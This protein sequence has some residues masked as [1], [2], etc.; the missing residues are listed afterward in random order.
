MSTQPHVAR[1]LIPLSSFPEALRR[2]LS[3]EAPE[4]VAQM[5]ARGLVPMPP[6]L[7]VCALYQV[8]HLHPSLAQQAGEALLV[9]PDEALRAVLSSGLPPSLLEWVA[10]V[11][12]VSGS[13]DQLMWALNNPRLS[14]ESGARLIRDGSVAVCERIGNDQALLARAPRLLQALY[15]APQTPRVLKDK[16][17][18]WAHYMKLPLQRSVDPVPAPAR[19]HSTHA[20]TPVPEQ[21]SPPSDK[22]G[23]GAPPVE[24][25]E[26]GAPLIP[27]VERLP[28]QLTGFS[29]AVARFLAPEAPD[30]AVRMLVSG[31]VPMPPSLRVLSLYHLS[32]TRPTVGDLIPNAVAQLDPATLL[33]V[34][35]GASNA[36]LIDWLAEHREGDE[37]L[38]GA[39]ISHPA[40][41]ALTL[42]RLALKATEELVERIALNQARWLEAPVILQALYFN[43]HLRASTS[44][45]VIELAARQG[46][47]L[48]WLPES[49]A[50]VESLTGQA[51]KPVA[52][53]ADDA[54]FSQALSEGQTRTPEETLAATIEADQAE[55]TGRAPE[56]AEEGGKKKGGYAAIMMMNVAQKIRLAL[57]GSQSD[58]A[59]LVKDSN[60]VVA[61]A[62][63]RSP[64]VSVSEALMYARNTSLSAPI[65]EY[66]ATNKK[67]MQN[68]RLRAQIVM[69]PKTP[70]HIALQALNTLRPPEL[71]AISQ[72]H[73]VPAVVS[74]RAKAIIK[75]RQG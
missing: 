67:W 21:V 68:Y 7:K 52:P 75:S 61:R 38:I 60:K 3:P 65:I 46:L 37:A 72:S 4:A 63:I 16:L 55:R 23:T 58:R 14:P 59:L 8:A 71:K 6:P 62:A 27:P 35:S 42:A 2:F 39:V 17:S 41:D 26:L 31:M 25:T 47:D 11:A 10:E 66:I 50:L 57:L 5:V 22:L 15:D 54:L 48:S 69:N 74:Q 64:S 73:G 70:T 24:Y 34:I 45:R 30:Q 20:P 1:P 33:E 43:P 40:C 51:S 12:S 19:T 9:I 18:E 32:V 29:P 36:G 49:E 56:P 13:L 28:L 53:S 44:D